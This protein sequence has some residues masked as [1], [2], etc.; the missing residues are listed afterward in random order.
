MLLWVQ[1]LSLV[2]NIWLHWILY[3]FNQS[4]INTYQID[5][6]WYSDSCDWQAF[7]YAIERPSNG[8]IEQK[9]SKHNDLRTQYAMNV[10]CWGGIV[11]KAFYLPKYTFYYQFSLNVYLLRFI[12][13]HWIRWLIEVLERQIQKGAFQQ[14][15]ITF[16]F[17]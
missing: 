15:L 11:F 8:L 5:L 3:D 16:G 2:L 14:I 12:E 1:D 9:S 6:Y 13:K 7:L 10:L 4:E 17:F